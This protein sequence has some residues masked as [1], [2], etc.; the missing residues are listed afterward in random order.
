MT[1]VAAEP[2][3]RMDDT[4]LPISTS[5]DRTTP[6]MG[7]RIV[8]L[9]SSSSERSTAACACATEARAWATRAS[10]TPSCDLATDC[11]FTAWSSA[12][13][14]SSMFCAEM[15]LSI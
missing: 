8:A 12:L 9:V 1:S 13:R 6:V 5:R 4:G 11:L 7:E 14:A 15:S 10:V 2:R 3:F